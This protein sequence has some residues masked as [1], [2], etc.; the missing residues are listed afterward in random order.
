MSLRDS[1]ADLCSPSCLFPVGVRSLAVT[2]LGARRWPFGDYN[3]FSQLTT[4][5]AIFC[6]YFPSVGWTS[7]GTALGSPDATPQP[8]LPVEPD[9][10]QRTQSMIEEEELTL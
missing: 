9:H 2:Y 10:P 5:C 3:F 1:S 4:L 6:R 8:Q 7:S